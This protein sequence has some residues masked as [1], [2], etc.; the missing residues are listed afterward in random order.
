MNQTDMQ[1][2][3]AGLTKDDQVLRHIPN[4]EAHLLREKAYLAAQAREYPRKGCPHP[5]SAI[6]QYL[7]DDPSAHRE[8]RPTNL[9]E[10]SICHSLLWL[11]SPYGEAASDG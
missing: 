4:P 7:D 11:V 9:F 3:L 6:E 10:C 8:S 2:F 5:I 1:N